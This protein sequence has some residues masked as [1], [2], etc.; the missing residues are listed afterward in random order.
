[1]A[2]FFDADRATRL[3]NSQKRYV[4]TRHGTTK[5]AR[6][7]LA[8]GG[9]SLVQPKRKGK[10]TISKTATCIPRKWHCKIPRTRDR[11]LQMMLDIVT[12]QMS[13]QQ[14]VSD[15]KTQNRGREQ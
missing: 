10:F 8:T 15:A 9:T 14:I 4:T 6:A 13:D 12:F 1:M 2:R 3:L 7:D 11:Q 5:L